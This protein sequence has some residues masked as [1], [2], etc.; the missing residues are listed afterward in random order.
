MWILRKFRFAGVCTLEIKPG[1]CR[2]DFKK[3]AFDRNIGSCKEF[4]YGG[5]RGNRNN[6]ETFAACNATCGEG[7]VI[8]CI[9]ILLISLWISMK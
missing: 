3:W 2:G 6:F 8:F 1:P 4:I 9:I 5:C 7:I